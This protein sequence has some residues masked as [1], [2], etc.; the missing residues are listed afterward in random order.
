MLPVEW[1]DFL[2]ALED[3][4]Q[5]RLY[6]SVNQKD[7]ERFVVEKSTDSEHFRVI[8]TVPARP[9]NGL[10]AYQSLDTDPQKGINY[11]RLRQESRDGSYSYSAIRTVLV[12]ALADEW[13]VSPNPVG[14]GQALHIRTIYDAPYRFRL[15]SVSGKLVA[16]K[17]GEGPM[18]IE[19][20][21]LPSGVYG[22]EILSERKKVGGKVVVE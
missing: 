18:S 15:F 14:K 20:L 17:T 9:E 12:E 22:Y 8:T 5:V 6:W 11:Y 3:N 2:A 13:T 16:E 19:G 21:D 10:F 4:R 7:V 1:F